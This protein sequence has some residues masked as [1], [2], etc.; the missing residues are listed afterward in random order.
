V[1]V[2][3]YAVQVSVRVGVD[4]PEDL[5]LAEGT[6]S[7]AVSLKS[8][9]ALFLGMEFVEGKGSN[10]RNEEQPDER[11]PRWEGNMTDN[12]FFTMSGSSPTLNGVDDAST[13]TV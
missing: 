13:E 4:R 3:R 8:P 1:H 11:L 5:P 7:G 9:H 6:S 10:R 12:T 2:K